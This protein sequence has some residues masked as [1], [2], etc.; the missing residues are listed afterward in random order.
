MNKT[1]IFVA[2]LCTAFVFSF[3]VKEDKHNVTQI[4]QYTVVE[5]GMATEKWFY[6]VN[7]TNP[8]EALDVVKKGKVE[9][10]DYRFVSDDN[11]HVYEVNNGWEINHP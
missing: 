10:Y 5:T 6:K 4:K 8:N 1:V 2:G 11:S 9:S 7:A 3:C